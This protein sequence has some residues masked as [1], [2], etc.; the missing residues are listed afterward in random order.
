MTVSLIMRK[1]I[2]LKISR[3]FWYYPDVDAYDFSYV[4]S[5][6]IRRYAFAYAA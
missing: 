3:L 1:A 5:S 2:I 4:A 6:L